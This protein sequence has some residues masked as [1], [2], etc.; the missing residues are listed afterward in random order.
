LLDKVTI[1]S[2]GVVPL[3]VFWCTDVFFS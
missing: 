2:D 1:Y 3:L